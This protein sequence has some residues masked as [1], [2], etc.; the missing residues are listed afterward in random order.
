VLEHADGNA[1][2]RGHVTQPDVVEAVTRD[3]AGR[4]GEDLLPPGLWLLWSRHRRSIASWPAIRTASCILQII[5]YYCL[6]V[7]I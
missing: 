5:P 2:L 3:R 4:S 1:G 7:E 6:D